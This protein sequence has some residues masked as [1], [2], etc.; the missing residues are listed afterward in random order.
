MKKFLYGLII[1]FFTLFLFDVL[2]A[3]HIFVFKKIETIILSNID[4]Q[5]D[6]DSDCTLVSDISCP[7]T[8]SPC[9]VVYLNHAVNSQS[10]NNWDKQNCPSKPSPIAWTCPDCSVIEQNV[11]AA[12]FSSK[13]VKMRKI[14]LHNYFFGK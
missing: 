10:L 14:T 13:C 6:S 9:G 12:C 4:N 3:K 5:C 7:D 8:C 1:F 2:A 11:K